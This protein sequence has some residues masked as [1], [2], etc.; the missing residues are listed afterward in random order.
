MSKNAYE[1]VLAN[2]AYVGGDSKV[3]Y[4]RMVMDEAIA[5]VGSVDAHDVAVWLE[6][7]AKRLHGEAASVPTSEWCAWEWRLV[8]QSNASSFA[9]MYIRKWFG[10]YMTCKSV[11]A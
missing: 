8:N 3:D 10:D 4:C 7:A 11:Y 1:Y 5:A 2:A 6:G 9:A